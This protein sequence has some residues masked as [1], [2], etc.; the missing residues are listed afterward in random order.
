MFNPLKESVLGTQF[1]TS[2]MTV[3]LFIADY[4]NVEYVVYTLPDYESD[5]ASFFTMFAPR[6]TYRFLHMNRN[7]DAEFAASIKT[8]SDVDRICIRRFLMDHRDLPAKNNRLFLGTDVYFLRIPDEILEFAW[9]GERSPVIYA[10]DTYTFAGEPYRLTYWR[11]AMLPGLLGDCYGVPGGKRLSVESIIGCLRMIDTWPTAVRYKPIPFT[12]DWPYACEQQATAILLSQFD[13]RALPLHLY[14]H[15]QASSIAVMV[16]GKHP[17]PIIG[18]FP[19]QIQKLMLEK[20][21][22]INKS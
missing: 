22:F 4:V 13:A 18:L 20:L 5:M 17:E 12:G 19:E 11:G 3:E 10:Q 8:A 9:G 1:A 7:E 21:A 15:L 14:C 2:L 16:H 6:A